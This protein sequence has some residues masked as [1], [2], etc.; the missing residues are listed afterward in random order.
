V[1]VIK[2]LY[3]VDKVGYVDT[4]YS[5]LYTVPPCLSEEE[6]CDICCNVLE[7]TTDRSD[8]W[9]DVVFL[10]VSMAGETK[11]AEELVL[12]DARSLYL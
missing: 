12:M 9:D 5:Q 4:R 8:R 2:N 3:S 11:H 7:P 1:A 10:L 6:W